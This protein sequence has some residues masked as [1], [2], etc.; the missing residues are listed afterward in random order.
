VAYASAEAGA[1][2]IYAHPF[3]GPGAKVRISTQGANSVRWSRNGKELFYKGG[4]AEGDLM[5]VDVQTAPAFHVSLP[6]AVVKT[7]FGTTWDPAPDGKRF[8][9]EQIPSLE[10]GSQRLQGVSD[11]FEELRRRVPVKR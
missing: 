1:I 7:G 2:D 3:P 11:W 8:L 4:A 9:I 6:H 5:A 10:A